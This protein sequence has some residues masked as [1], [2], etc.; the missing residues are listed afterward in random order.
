MYVNTH[1]PAIFIFPVGEILLSAEVRRISPR[2][3]V[4]SSACSLGKG[5]DDLKIPFCPNSTG[6]NA[7]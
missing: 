3:G 1:T 2:N 7:P 4:G 6:L 5:P